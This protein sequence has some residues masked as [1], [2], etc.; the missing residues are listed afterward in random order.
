MVGEA[1]GTTYA[2]SGEGIGKAMASALLAAECLL[3][4]GREAPETAYPRRLA[5]THGARYAAYDTAQRWLSHPPLCN[6]LA[7]RAREGRFVRD[8]LADLLQEAGEPRRLFSLSGLVR[9]AFH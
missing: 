1:A 2:F 8:Q 5:A 7:R 6:W 3:A 4:G 9:A